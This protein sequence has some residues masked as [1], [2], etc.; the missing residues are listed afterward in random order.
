MTSLAPAEK[1][2]AGKPL[3]VGSPHDPAER[4]ADR[5]ADLLTAPEEPALPVCAACATGGAPCPA[6]GGGGGEG[7]LQRQVA[8][9]RES[10]SE[11]EM[12]APPSVHRVLSEPGKALPPTM[13][14]LT[15]S[16]PGDRYEQEADRVADQIMRM[17]DPLMPAGKAV[18][19]L[20]SPLAIQRITSVAGV[21]QRR[22]YQTKLEDQ[23]KKI[24]QAKERA[25]Y[26]LQRISAAPAGRFQRELMGAGEKS[27][28]DEEE[29]SGRTLQSKSLPDFSIQ[30]VASKARE[31]LTQQDKEDVDNIAEQSERNEQQNLQAKKQPAMTSKATPAFEAR[32][33]MSRGKGHSL[34]DEIRAFM[35]ERFGKDF[36]DA[37][38]HS[39]GEA[40]DLNRELQAQAFTHGHDMFFGSGKYNPRT[41][42]GKYLLAHELTHVV[43]QEGALAMERG[44]AIQRIPV[45]L[46]E[47]M[48]KG[49]EFLA[50]D[51]KALIQYAI[52][53]ESVSAIKYIQDYGLASQNE[54]YALIDVLT[55]QF[56]VGPL[57]EIALLKIWNSFGSGRESLEAG[58]AIL[59]AASSRLGLNLWQRS[60]DAGARLDRLPQIIAFLEIF[61]FLAKAEV[62]RMLDE[63]KKRVDEVRERYGITEKQVEESR[64]VETGGEKGTLWRT[65]TTVSTQ[66]EMPESSASSEVAIAASELLE[67]RLEINKLQTEQNA[68]MDTVCN[69]SRR[70]EICYPRIANQAAY[71]ELTAKIRNAKIDYNKLLNEKVGKCPELAPLGTSESSQLATVAKGQPNQIAQIIGPMMKEILGNIQVSSQGLNENKLSVWHLPPV[72][73]LT[74]QRLNLKPGGLW[75]VLVDEKKAQV[76]EDESLINAALSVAAG[77][78][79]IAAAIPSGGSSLAL[80][81]T[82]AALGASFGISGGL[83][84][85][86][87]EQYSLQEAANATDFVKAKAISNEEPSLF[88]LAIDIISFGLDIYAAS[89]VF[90]ALRET[91]K[92]ATL[93]GK[94][95]GEGAEVGLTKADDAVEALRKEGNAKAPGLGERL[96]QDAWT[97]RKRV[98]EESAERSGRSS[99]MAVSKA[100][101]AVE[102]AITLGKTA[103]GA[104]ELKVLTTGQ[105]VVCSKHPCMFMEDRFAGVLSRN[106]RLND[107]VLGLM[108]RIKPMLK[109]GEPEKSKLREA[110]A[111]DYQSLFERCER[112]PTLAEQVQE[113]LDEA[114]NLASGEKQ[115]YRGKGAKQAAKNTAADVGEWGGRMRAEKDGLT[116]IFDNPLGMSR[117]QRGV[118]SIFRDGSGNIWIIEYKG[119]EAR[120]KPNQ[121]SNDWVNRKIAEMIERLGPDEPNAKMLRDALASGRLKG[122]TYFTEIDKTTG[123]ALKTTSLRAPRLTMLKKYFK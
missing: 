68:L 28:D 120:L 119:G 48:L 67:R 107:E 18:P 6:C 37:R 79:A 118:D 38:V 121:M 32:L 103:D 19:E 46:T 26:L 8:G 10:V 1:A 22:Q 86:Q 82:S 112:K 77:V 9:G 56:W 71:N 65:E 85:Y 31:S 98:L 47:P 16:E 36:S 94:V 80:L 41:V 76:D 69:T 83:L 57:E 123:F 92:T 61:E 100:V 51:D 44:G 50:K 14:Q 54:K 11:G 2:P 59:E 89:M 33:N 17:P 39:D 49:A 21:N 29:E 73:A 13:A 20:G 63:S 116:H 53:H 115:P 122:R 95:G 23:E 104:H 81:G 5:I 113:D 114:M 110:L 108:K 27:E 66:Y 62:Y 70:E 111:R 93:V 97:E 25:G 55:S 106:K 117:N 74:K 3:K 58:K 105:L 52:E 12:V 60:V 99:D 109:A 15:V 24:V 75:D 78:L 64:V 4:E 72:L 101:T 90:K 91:A 40:A 45:G 96:F 35:E 88:W 42:D 87:I 43:Q 7:M 102:D 30:S 84:A 34:P